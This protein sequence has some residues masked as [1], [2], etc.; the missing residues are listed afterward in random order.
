MDS[1]P[2]S[3][4]KRQ[5]ETDPGRFFQPVIGVLITVIYFFLLAPILVVVIAS[6]SPDTSNT[7]EISRA[8]LHWYRQFIANDSFVSAFSFSVVLALIASFGATSIGLVTAY[9]LV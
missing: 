3:A 2:R 8:S 4:G 9:G 7:Y 6:F 1:Y 5:S